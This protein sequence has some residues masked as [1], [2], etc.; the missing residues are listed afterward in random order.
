DLLHRLNVVPIRVPALRER[1]EDIAVLA[2]HFLK[3]HSRKMR[4]AL[5]RLTAEA[6][7]ALLDGDYP[8]NVRDLENVIVRGLVMSENEGLVT[9]GEVG[10]VGASDATAEIGDDTEPTNGE[11]AIDDESGGLL[12][13]VSRFEREWIE[14]ALAEAGGNRTKAARTLKISKRWLLKKLE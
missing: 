14:R 4:M 11:A 1:R 12:D 13:R 2:E 8:G 3:L 9:A 10:G 5:P 6:R 7:S